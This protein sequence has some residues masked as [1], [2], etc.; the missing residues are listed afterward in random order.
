MAIKQSTR[1]ETTDGTLY[2]SE[3]DAHKSSRRVK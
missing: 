3:K 1:F 2:T